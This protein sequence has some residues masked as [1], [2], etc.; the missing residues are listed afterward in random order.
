MGKKVEFTVVASG[1]ATQ[2]VTAANR[3]GVSVDDT[4]EGLP[5]PLRLADRREFAFVRRHRSGS[6]DLCLSEG[7]RIHLGPSTA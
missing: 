3:A 1:T 4:A 5:V 2:N 7:H 6:T